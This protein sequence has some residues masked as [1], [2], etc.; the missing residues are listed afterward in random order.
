MKIYSN[1]PAQRWQELCDRPAAPSEDLERTVREVFEDVSV[2]G[3]EALKL[4][5]RRFDKVDIPDVAMPADE[6]SRLA[7]TV[8]DYLRRAID[9]AYDNIRN[10][11][12]AQALDVDS[13]RVETSQ[14]VVCWRETRPIE[15]VGLYV[16]GGSAP[17]ISTVLMLGVPAQLARCG[18]VVLCTPPS[19]D[20]KVDPAIC[21]AALKVGVTQLVRVGGIQAVA[22]LATGAGSVGK[23]DKILGPGNR[24]VTAAKQYAASNAKVAIDMPAGPSEVLVVAD[25]SADSEFVAADLLS[26]AEH[27]PDSQAILVT[28]DAVLASSASKAVDRQLK[29]L[30]RADV[31]G[32]ALKRSFCVVFD[33]M[34]TA[35]EFSNTYAPEHMILAVRKTRS[36]VP[37]V[38][39]AG[40]VFIGDYSPVTAGDYASGTNHTLP[41]DGWARSY[42]GVSLDSF[43]KNITF[44]SLTKDGLRGIAPTLITLAAAEGLDAHV[45]SVKIRMEK[46]L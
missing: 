5:T 24:Y 12:C 38:L 15:R 27:G 19:P 6:T 36:F 18:R 43:V 44:Q 9:Q 14:G 35:L 20:G 39:S 16:P 45:N 37:K 8:P 33:S 41:T 4:Y 11:H 46:K 28:D 3:D 2:G 29:A 1:P 32:Q 30:P 17:L 40:S 25:A 31:T 13:Q 34:D 7:A 42:G 23:V 21:Y 10:F 26:Q 22:A